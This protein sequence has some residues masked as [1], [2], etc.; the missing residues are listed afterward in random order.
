MIRDRGFGPLA[1]E[2]WPGRNSESGDPVVRLS[3]YVA[4]MVIAPLL[5]FLQCA[6]IVTDRVEQPKCLGQIS[7]IDISVVQFCLM[8]QNAVIS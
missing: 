4:A 3:S 8:E 1:N 6:V 7:G 5:H 2:K